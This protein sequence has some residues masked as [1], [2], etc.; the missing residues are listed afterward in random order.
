MASDYVPLKVK[1][2][3][4]PAGLGFNA[5]GP[6]HNT[7]SAHN[8]KKHIIVAFPNHPPITPRSRNVVPGVCEVFWTLSGIIHALPPALGLLLY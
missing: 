6:H 4:S 3:I 5:A 8:I 2:D 1:F 7:K